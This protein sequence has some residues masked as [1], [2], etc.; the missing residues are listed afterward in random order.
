MNS[1]YFNQFSL[2]EL[3][4]E[5]TTVELSNSFVYR[6]FSG[7]FRSGGRFY[8]GLE[9]NASKDLRSRILINGNPT[10]EKDFS[11]MHINMLYNKENQSL[12]E[13]AYNKLSGGIRNYD[14]YSS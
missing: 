7:S 9:S 3:R 5:T 1:D 2:T 10:V 4:P 6:V 8:N 12:K 13:N 11:C 14:S